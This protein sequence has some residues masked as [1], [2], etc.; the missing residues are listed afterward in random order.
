MIAGLLKSESADSASG[1]PG[2]M[3]IPI[4][5][6]LFRS[7]SFRANESELLIIVTA[8]LVEPYGTP[9]AETITN[10]VTDPFEQNNVSDLGLEESLEAG[11]GQT[12]TTAMTLEGTGYLID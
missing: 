7:D 10:P 5:G 11:Y 6:Q 3:N 2:A 1:V 12:A 4:L 8:L 9:I